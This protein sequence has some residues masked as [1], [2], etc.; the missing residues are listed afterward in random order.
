MKT[1]KEHSEKQIWGKLM[2]NNYETQ[3][4][5]KHFEKMKTKHTHFS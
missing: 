1:Y 4:Y 2:N 3:I 5:E